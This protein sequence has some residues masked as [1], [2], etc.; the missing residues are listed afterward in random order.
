M[1]LSVPLAVLAVLALVTC[2]SEDL[3]REP[4]QQAR[5]THDQ[6][7]RTQWLS[8]RTAP[9]RLIIDSVRRETGGTFVA[10]SEGRTRTESIACAKEAFDRKRPFLLCDG[11]WGMDSYIE[12]GVAG[13][14]NGNV[15]FY[16][17]D[18]FGPRYRGTC[19]RP[20][21]SFAPDDWPQCR[22]ALL[23]QVDL[24]TGGAY[25]ERTRQSREEDWPRPCAAIAARA[26]RWPL[27]VHLVSGE[28]PLPN[29]QRWGLRCRDAVVSFE[30]IID[31][32]GRP[33]CVRILE[34]GRRAPVQIPGLYDSI[35]QRLRRWRFE[36][37]TLHDEP[38]EVRW[39]MT[40]NTIRQ[41][42][43]IPGP[44]IYPTCP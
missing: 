14:P 6:A 39:G 40:V 34:V 15:L 19:L 44:P 43:S 23:Q 8:S 38:V 13:V 24:N 28:T 5:P 17:L 16:Y 1:K 2:D 18:T 20:N 4:P 29:P 12:T 36:P 27:G 33:K 22:T 41:G 30:M 3:P 32:T 10:C 25:V 9:C 26:P 42:E 21:V 7:R 11:G 31:K 35:R 37:P